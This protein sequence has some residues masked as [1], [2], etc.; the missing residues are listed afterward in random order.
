M[1]KTFSR[2]L[3]FGRLLRPIVLVLGAIGQLRRQRLPI[4][5]LQRT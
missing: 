4:R 3:L 2:V 1:R 5:Q